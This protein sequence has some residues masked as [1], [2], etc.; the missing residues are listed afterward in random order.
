MA[1]LP[2]QS[3]TFSL[4]TWKVIG[5]LGC[6]LYS[7]CSHIDT[8]YIII[9]L[10]FFF[11]I[12]SQITGYKRKGRKEIKKKNRCSIYIYTPTLEIADDKNGKQFK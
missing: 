11:I 4:F 8:Q 3:E 10:G 7:L 2:L 5:I 6:H 9:V 12:L 1:L